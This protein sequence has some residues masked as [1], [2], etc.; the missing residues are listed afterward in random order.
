MKKLLLYIATIVCGSLGLLGILRVLE[1][2]AFAGSANAY[3]LGRV[4]GQGLFAL[5]LLLLGWKAYS[6]ARAI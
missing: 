5:L 1:L 2:L 4:I 6:K 3:S